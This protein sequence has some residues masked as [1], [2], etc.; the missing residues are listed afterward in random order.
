MTY[1][2]INLCY[3]GEEIDLE[4]SEIGVSS[5]INMYQ[6]HH[7]Q[8]LS[9]NK[10]QNKDTMYNMILDFEHVNLRKPSNE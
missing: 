9:D 4:D 6:L 2:M 8:V 7:Q 5:Q 1:N 3:N 10:D